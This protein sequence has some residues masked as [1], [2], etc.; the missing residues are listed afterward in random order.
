MEI[1]QEVQTSIDQGLINDNSIRGI[2]VP[3][4]LSA[5]EADPEEVKLR[6]TSNVLKGV[7]KLKY[8]RLLEK[9]WGRGGSNFFYFTRPELSRQ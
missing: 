2:S 6:N 1:C 5:L 7:Y 3:E 8:S 4:I 9:G